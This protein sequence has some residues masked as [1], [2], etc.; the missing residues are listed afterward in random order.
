MIDETPLLSF[1]E[2]IGPA[3]VAWL[4]TMGLLLVV[5]LVACWLLAAVRHGPVR[6]ARSVC[7]VFFAGLGD[8][9]RISPR[10][11][12]ALAWL[13]VKESIRRRTVAVFVVFLVLLLFAG[14]FLD[15]ESVNRARLYITF[16][17]TATSYLVLLLSLF[18]SVLSLPG[19]IKNRTIYTLMTKPVRP[20]EIVLGRIVGFV[21]LGTGLLALMG[22]VSYVFVCRGMRHTHRV[23]VARLQADDTAHGAQLAPQAWRG[24]TSLAQGHRHEV[25][26]DALGRGRVELENNHWHTLALSPELLANKKAVAATSGPEGMLVARV[27][28]YGKLRF[29]DRAGKPADKGINVGDEWTYRSYIE[30]GTLAA[31]VWTFNN[32]TAAEYPNGL[33]V[34][35]NLGVF[36]THK[37]E[38]Q[39]GVPGSLTVRNPQTGLRVEVRIFPAKEFVTDVQLIPRE[40]QTADGRRVDLLHDLVADGQ[41]EIWLRC[42]APAQYFGVAQRDLY[43]RARDTSFALNFAKG[44]LGI[45]LQMVVLVGFGVMFS[46]FLSGPVAMIATLAVLVIGFFSGFVSDLARGKNIGGGPMESAIRLVT[47]DN[48]VSEL[49]PGLRT[50][51]AKMAD[52]AFEQVLR[53]VVA[54]VP[55]FAEFSYADFVADGFHIPCDRVLMGLATM[56]AFLLPVYVVG[57]FFLKTREVAR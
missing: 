49:E 27:P 14:W 51:A 33:P 32:V 10:R 36:R 40:L 29:V 3:V 19:D 38:M 23:E 6:G 25:F 13:A 17:L 53:G 56:L 15:P 39:K 34:E 30:G 42:L 41:V 31:A 2:W 48:L 43:L 20:A 5:S 57:Y 11:M 22:A 55:S 52:R 37:G 16:V 54:A 26:L 4:A 44:Y 12:A 35:L 24:R 7:G 21:L 8:L 46:T 18:L 47:Q 1:S 9:L 50:T 45:W 28:V